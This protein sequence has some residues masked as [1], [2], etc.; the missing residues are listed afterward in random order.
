MRV[1][2]RGG[3]P[4]GGRAGRYRRD[5]TRASRGDPACGPRG[6]PRWH[7]RA[8]A[9][10]PRAARSRPGSRPRR[11]HAHH[12]REQPA[13]R[14]ARALVAELHLE[15]LVARRAVGRTV[16]CTVRRTVG[17]GGG[18]AVAERVHA[19]ERHR[20]VR[21]RR[22]HLV[23][24]G[25]RVSGAHVAGVLAIVVEV[26]GGEQPVLVADEAVAAHARRVELH[27]QLDVAR[28]DVERRA[29]LG[30]EHLERPGEVVD[31][32]VV[33]VAHL[34][35]LL[36][37]RVL[38]VAGAEARHGERRPFGPLRLDQP[39]ERAVARH[40]D[41]EAAVG[42]G[43][44]AV[45]AAVHAR[46]AR[47]PVGEDEPLAAGGGAARLQP[48]DGGEDARLLVARRARGDEPRVAGVD[49]DRHAERARGA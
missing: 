17:R 46:R 48:V 19:G 39:F 44:H 37:L 31:V 1:N 42:G 4:S 9:T 7:R 24:R 16:G 22:L 45:D 32:G 47:D 21:P 15:Q 36:H 26:L 41:V 49:H 28:H 18:R 3:R 13:R 27:L 38:I 6:S 11:R 34:G 12:A 8:G 29:H 14:L 5:L 33:A 10:A 2:G 35:E 43:D 25:D 23:E 40:A 20:R 30:D